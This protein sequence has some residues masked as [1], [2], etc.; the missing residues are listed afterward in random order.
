MPSRKESRGRH[1]C[2]TL[3]NWTEEEYASL[4]ALGT[5]LPDPVT[6]LCV[7]KETGEE[8]TP[9]LQGFVSLSGRKSFSFVKRLISGRCH[10]EVARSRPAVAASYC[11]KDGDYEEF[12]VV[13]KGAGRRNDLHEAVAAIKGGMRKREFAETFPNVYARAFRFISECYLL[14]AEQRVWVPEVRV[15]WGATGT[16]KTRRAIEEA[17]ED[18]Y[19]HPGGEWFDGYEGQ[20]CVI[21]DDFG[22]HEFKLTYLLKLLDRYPMRVPVKGSFVVWAPKMIWLTSNTDPKLWYQGASL[23]HQAALRRRISFITHFNNPWDPENC[24]WG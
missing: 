8:G 7:G 15:F 10:L 13:P 2:F 16:G 9:H 20:P 6:Y 14:F 23:E 17:G 3:N 19:I 4:V 5:E 21:F 1:W 12:G 22:G 18:V 24:V 11:K